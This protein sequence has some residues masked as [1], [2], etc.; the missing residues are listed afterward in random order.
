[1]VELARDLRP[2]I[3]VHADETERLRRLPDAVVRLLRGSGF[4]GM[5]RPVE[6][7]GLGID[8]L[9][10]MRAVEEISVA[11]AST[12]WCAA[13]GSGSIGALRLR[14]E[15]AREIFK[16]GTALA[17]VGSPSGR[18]TPVDGGYRV[19]GRWSY[20]SGC[21]HSDWLFAG[22]VVFD[23]DAPRVLDGRPDI[24]VVIVP[25]SDIEIIDTWHVSGLRGT[26]SH[27]VAMHDL[28]VPEAR[29]SI[30]RLDGGGADNGG[31]AEVPMFTLF[32][33]ALVPVAFGAARRAIDELIALAQGKTPMMSGSKLQDKPVFQHELARAEGDLQAGRAYLYDAVAEML[34]RVSRNQAVDM[35]M[36]GR[37]KLAT[38][39]GVA[40]AADAVDIAYRL[41]GGTSN[42][43]HSVIQRCF[44]DVHAVT[45]HFVVAATNY[46]VAGRVLLGL[47][48][49]TPVI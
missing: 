33:L 40:L 2:Q 45:Q 18:A 48:P 28:F 49:G 6:Y 41:G 22:T 32:G 13:I 5:A 37:V 24:R 15:V 19:T 30:M 10:T 31:P 43:E 11:D 38:T 17:G 3:Q 42:F 25:V 23:G 20:A 29:T 12:G 21:Q 27:D 16:P 34:E 39:H 9:T 7:G 14:D 47:D 46:E 36:R 35:A 26:G 4:F 44:R 8:L 1:M